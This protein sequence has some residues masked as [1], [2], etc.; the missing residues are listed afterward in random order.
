MGGAG[1]GEGGCE[2]GGAMII[3]Q[4][5]RASIAASTARSGTLSNGGGSDPGSTSEVLDSEEDIGNE[6]MNWTNAHLDSMEQDLDLMNVEEDPEE[7]IAITY[8]VYVQIQEKIILVVSKFL[9]D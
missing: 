3:D 7:T 6:G 9:C 4:H 8:E 1:G 5:F 2:Q